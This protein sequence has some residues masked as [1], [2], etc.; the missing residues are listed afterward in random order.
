MVT[1]STGAVARHYHHKLTGHIPPQDAAREWDAAS[2]CD[3]VSEY[4]AS[5]LR[6]SVSLI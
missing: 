1:D 4:D 2:Y 3:A 6:V 5:M